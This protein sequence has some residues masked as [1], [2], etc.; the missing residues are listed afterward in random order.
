[1]LVARY[2]VHDAQPWISPR[3]TRLGQR[4][5]LIKIHAATGEQNSADTLRN[6]KPCHLVDIIDTAS[7]SISELLDEHD[8][9]VTDAGFQVFLLR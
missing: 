9:T 5:W 6:H 7:D 3:A 4:K 1:M 2:S 8:N